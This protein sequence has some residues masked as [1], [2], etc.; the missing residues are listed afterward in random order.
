MVM[1]IV[2]PKTDFEDDLYNILVFYQET[3][4]SN[5]G[6]VLSTNMEFSF[7]V[8]VFYFQDELSTSS[9]Y[10]PV[11]KQQQF[12]YLRDTQYYVWGG[13][14]NYVTGYGDET[15]L[16]FDWTDTKRFFGYMTLWT[17]DEECYT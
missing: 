3:N 6:K 11:M 8:D 16:S 12:E 5:R 1:S 7:I 9:G 13:R 15:S 4:I 14:T 17:T 2:S 10:Q